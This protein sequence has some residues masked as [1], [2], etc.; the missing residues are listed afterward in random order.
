MEKSKPKPT[1]VKNMSGS[2]PPDNTVRQPNRVIAFFRETIWELKRVRWP[3]R[4][5][6]VNYTTAALIT[7]VIMGGLVWVFDIGVAKVLSLI[8][9]V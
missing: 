7:C 9:L 4:R 6:V 3:G 2:E 1:V 8:G 5:E